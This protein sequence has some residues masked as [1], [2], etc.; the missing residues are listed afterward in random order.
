MLVDTTT[1]A[2]VLVIPSDHYLEPLYRKKLMRA[3]GF[4]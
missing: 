2:I 3:G 1:L 4:R